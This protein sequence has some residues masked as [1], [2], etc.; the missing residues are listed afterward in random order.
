MEHSAEYEEA[1]SQRWAR[2]GRDMP[3]SNLRQ[4]DYPRDA[5]MLSNPKGTAPGLAMEHQGKWIFAMP[6]VPEEMELMLAEQVL[7]RLRAVAGIEEVLVSRLVRTWGRPES[8]VGDRLDDMFEVT[9]PSIAFLASAGEIKI[10]ITAKAATV[11]EANALIVPVEEEVRRRLGSAVFGADIETIE[12]A[13][14]VML[15]GRGWT[16]GTAESMTGGL[17]SARLTSLSGSSRF[18]R[19]GVVAYATELKQKLLAVEDVADGVV[20]EAVAMAMAEG[21]R[22]LVGADV[23]VS[24][25]GSAGPEAMEQPAGTVVIGVA[26]PEGSSAR[27]M[28]FAGDR[29]RVR[30]YSTTAALHLVRLAVSGE[31]WTRR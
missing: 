5:E 9:N 31:W 6:G 26:T 16:I 19:G 10:R 29:E 11:E 27:T 20:N 4:A 28:K 22:P 30:T 24:V 2:T 8:W 13:L 3:T 12:S 21:V 17:V 15:E 7:P 18:Y 23:G 25:T 14:F 1:L